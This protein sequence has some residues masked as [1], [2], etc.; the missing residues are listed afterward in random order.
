MTSHAHPLPQIDN[1]VEA[2]KRAKIFSTLDL[3]LG[4]WQDPI[5]EEHKSKK[6]FR[7]S[8]GQLYEFSQLP[9]GLCNAPATFS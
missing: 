8:S 4:Y 2:L 5:K 1:T 6:A 9:F 7:T 3:K